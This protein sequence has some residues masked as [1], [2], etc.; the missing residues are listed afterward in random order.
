MVALVLVYPV[1]FF[2]WYL[3]G[4]QV[5]A[6]IIAC[7]TRNGQSVRCTATGQWR[8]PDGSTA[9]GRIFGSEWRPGDIGSTV[10]VRAHGGVA[11]ADGNGPL[12]SG[13]GLWATIV[14][15]VGVAVLIFAPLRIRQMRRRFPRTQ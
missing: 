8:L 10:P 4:A 9:T 12:S 7:P 2:V 1:A 14:G 5:D 6:H 13:V 3:T 11:V 15:V